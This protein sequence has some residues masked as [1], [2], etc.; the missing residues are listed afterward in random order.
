M[1]T[2]ILDQDGNLNTGGATLE[3]RNWLDAA[4]TAAGGRITDGGFGCGSADTGYIVDGVQYDAQLTRRK[5][6]SEQPPADNDHVAEGC[7]KF[8]AAA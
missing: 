8:E 5:V 4:I 3:D 2:Q 1:N 6:L 7:E